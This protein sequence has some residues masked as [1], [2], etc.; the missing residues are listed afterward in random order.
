[1]VDVAVIG[2]GMTGA[3]IACLLKSAGL[4][5]AVVEKD[6]CGQKNTSCTTAHLTHVTDLRITQLV[7]KFGK[8][9]AQAV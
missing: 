7:Q 1:M 6:R 9:H 8:D 5:V 4:K 3:S 2:G